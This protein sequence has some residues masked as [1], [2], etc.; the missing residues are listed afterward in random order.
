[1]PPR[2]SKEWSV[3][4]VNMSSTLRQERT[5]PCEAACPA[6]NNIQMLH[7]ALANGKTD[8]ALRC[9]YAK[10]PFPGITGRVCPHPCEEQCNRCSYDEGVAIHSLERF[11]ADNGSMPV[12]KPLPATGKKVAIVGAGPAGLTAARFLR[13]TG[14]DVTVYESS[15]VMGG[16]MRHSIPDFR[17]P[18][19]VVDR[20]TGAI[21]GIGVK[22]VTN[23]SVG[24]DI[25]LKDILDSFD[26]CILAA[27]LWQER[28]LDIEG[29]Q[30]LKP[31]VS[32]M[33]STTLER[34]SLNGKR[35]AII[36]GG[37]VAFD[38]AFTAKRL[39]AESVC[40]ISLEAEDQLHAPASEIAQAHEEDIV[41]H[42]GFN[43]VAITQQGT[44][45]VIKAQPIKGFS[46]ADNGELL[47]EASE[48]AIQSFACD[49]VICA[50]GLKADLSCCQGIEIALTPKGLVQTNAS[51]MT[52]IPGLFAAG[53]IAT[54]PSLVSSAIG[55]GRRVAL[56]VHQFLSEA[57]FEN[58]L[59]V[60]LNDDGILHLEQTA[61]AN[62]AQYVVPLQEIKHVDYHPHAERHEPS[63]HAGGPKLAFAELEG[64][65]DAENAMQEAARCLHCGHCIACGSCVESCPGHIL[66]LNEDGPYVAYPDECWHCGCCRIACSCGAVS[67][68]FP[69]TMMV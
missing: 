40:L 65:F 38:S 23:V 48:E 59:D 19:D 53:D 49:L 8:E 17:L 68:L 33:K 4:A 66:D 47:T 36:G 13:Q 31:A 11:A 12:L 67:Y 15:P 34:Q 54:G 45:Y 18:K 35:V 64:G 58:G 9:I 16:L 43:T 20:E 3:V 61:S 51:Y 28:I 24:T 25:M 30:Y 52:N 44:E 41:L 60:W 69:I 6:G 26:A 55:N 57:T 39:G 50:S 37:G 56:S 2:F 21:A 46:F 14:H 10:N 32:W 42:T 1:M 63:L 22:V 27:G 5:S 62:P 7:T 29:K